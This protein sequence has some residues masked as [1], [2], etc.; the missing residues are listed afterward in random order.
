MIVAFVGRHP[1]HR[2]RGAAAGAAG[3]AG[4]A[5]RG[6][7]GRG[8]PGPV[9]DPADGRRRGPAGRRRGRRGLGLTGSRLWVLGL[10]AVLAFLGVALLSPL[11]SRPVPARWARCSP[12]GCRAG[13]AG[14]NSQR[15]PR[16]T[17]TTAAALMVGLALV[18]RGRRARRVAEGAASAR[19][20]TTALGADFILNPA[21][22]GISQQAVDAVRPLPGLAEVTAF[23]SAAGRAGRATASSTRPRCRPARSARTVVARTTSGG[24]TELRP[25]ALLVADDLADGPGAVG[26]LDGVGAA[27]R[28]APPSSCASAART[29]RTIWSATTC[30]TP[31]PGSH[32][33]QDLYAAALIEGG[34]GRGRRAGAGR[35]GAGRSAA[36]P[37]VQLQDRSEFVGDITSQIDQLVQFFTL[38]LA[39]SVLIAVLG[40]VNTLALSVL[41]RTRELGLLRAVGLSR[42]QMKRMVR[43]ESV[44]SRSSAA[45]SASRSAR[46]SGSALQRALVDEGIT[47]LAFPVGQLV[48][49]LLLAAV[50]GVLAAVAAGAPGVPAQRAER[51]RGG[52]SRAGG[53]G[54]HP[55]PGAAALRRSRL[56]V[57]SCRHAGTAGVSRE[58]ARKGDRAPR[59]RSGGAAEEVGEVGDADVGQRAG[60]GPPRRGGHREPGRHHE[61]L[62]SRPRPRTRPRSASPPPPPCPP[63]RRPAARPPSG[64]APGAAWRCR[65]RPSRRW[66]RRARRAAARARPAP[67]AARV[68]VTSATGTPAARTA[69]TS[70][71]APGSHA[72]PAAKPLPRRA[73]PAAGQLAAGSASKRPTSACTMPT[74]TATLVPTVAARAA[75]DSSPPSSRASCR[76]ASSQTG[77]E[78][79]SVPSRSKSTAAGSGHAGS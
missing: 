50:A 26:R 54:G 37:N 73:R 40:I 13:W 44:W 69:S 47:E 77:S 24:S 43:V 62:R 39:L 7:A 46:S 16:R 71:W 76:S 10:G 74:D 14:C 48:V 36:Y 64:T 29:S 60:E 65:R 5:G 66:R 72:S 18:S 56:R 34:A 68:F 3:G 79:S 38:L 35:A 6:D 25:G 28:T 20:R 63:G 19:P 70:S 59:G 52:L 1:G 27:T 45:C 49:Y 23:R 67:A 53:A 57:S 58:P 8:D 32:F 21:A 42:R 33:D 51:H 15:N 78:S 2:G 61:H 17:A 30:W 4:P 22:V 55:T 9:A 41:E 75:A 31:A 12:G 11:V